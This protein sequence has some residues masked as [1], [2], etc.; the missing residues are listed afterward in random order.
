MLVIYIHTSHEAT[1]A[2]GETFTTELSDEREPQIR[3]SV[4]R[5]QRKARSPEH[6]AATFGT[7]TLISDP[8]C[9]T[10]THTHTHTLLPSVEAFVFVSICHV[11]TFHSQLPFKCICIQAECGSES[12][13]AGVCVCV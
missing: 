9:I 13:W 1:R 7:H 12:Q 3:P 4:N 5:L 6:R 2:S 11:N 10:I 8:L